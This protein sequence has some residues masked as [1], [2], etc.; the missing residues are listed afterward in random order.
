MYIERTVTV[1]FR[2]ADLAF[3]EH[4]YVTAHKTFSPCPEWGI[5][6]G[7]MA[8]PVCLGYRGIER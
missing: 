6:V 3:G 2:S 1:H 4:P 5:L 7:A 8:I